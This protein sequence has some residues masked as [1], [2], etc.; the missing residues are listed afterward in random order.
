MLMR[1][2]QYKPL[3]PK[4]SY[5]GSW[6]L[7]MIFLP[8]ESDYKVPVAIKYCEGVMGLKESDDMHYG[9]KD[10]TPIRG[11][12][13]EGFEQTRTTRNNQSIPLILCV[14]QMFYNRY[15]NGKRLRARP[16]HSVPGSKTA[17]FIVM[18]YLKPLEPFGTRL[19]EVHSTIKLWTRILI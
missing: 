1:C 6:A 18:E 9:A 5:V 15:E 13:Y 12:N 16:A 7:E 10:I 4:V 3:F 2:E 8:Q 11:E 19:K 14:F 17:K